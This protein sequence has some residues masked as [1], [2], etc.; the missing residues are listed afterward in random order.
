MGSRGTERVTLGGAAIALGT[1]VTC[2]L[3]GMV[4]GV[5]AGSVSR[6]LIVLVV[7]VPVAA[8]VGA[9]LAWLTARLMAPV[10]H[11]W[12]HIVAFA[13]TGALAS[14]PMALY[15]TRGQPEPFAVLTLV[16]AACAAVGRASI[17]R[18]ATLHDGPSHHANAERP[19]SHGV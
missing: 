18:L 2:L 4:M 19:G 5:A 11:Q 10:R 6:A 13:G 3:F 15:L 14:A 1:A 9:P 8:L 16:P 12:W 17:W 7:S